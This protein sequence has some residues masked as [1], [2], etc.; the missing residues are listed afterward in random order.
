MDDSHKKKNAQTVWNP[1]SSAISL[2]APGCYRVGQPQAE[3]RLPWVPAF[4]GMTLEGVGTKRKIR[5]TSYGR[6]KANRA[7]QQFPLFMNPGIKDASYRG[8]ASFF[9]AT[10]GPF[11]PSCTMW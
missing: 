5:I 9:Q 4:A 2:L 10:G 11:L 8:T 3:C 1:A 6:P 7:R